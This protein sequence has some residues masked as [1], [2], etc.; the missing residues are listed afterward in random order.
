LPRISLTAGVNSISSDLFVLQ[1]RDNPVW[2][3]GANL[4][5][6]IFQGGALKAQVEIRTAEQK[7]A[8]AEYARAALRAFGEAENALA[9]EIASQD[10]EQILLRAVAENDRALELAKVSFNVGSID[11]RPVQ[12]Q[13]LAL[14][15]T[16][17]ALV[18]VQSE[19]RLQRVNLHLALGG[20]WQAA[21]S[22]EAKPAATGAAPA[23]QQSA[24][25]N[26][27]PAASSAPT[28][29]TGATA[30]QDR[31]ELSRDTDTWV[32]NVYHEKGIGGVA[33]TAPASGWPRSMRTRFHG[34]PGLEKLT[35]KAGT[36]L[37]ACETRRPE[38]RPAEDIC[39]LNGVRTIAPRKLP[40]IYEV[41]LP[42]DILV[43]AHRTLELRWVD[44]WR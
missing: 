20:G 25:T 17:S 15:A 30:L 36:S 23:V 26:A 9:S 6:P 39:T 7:Q 38:G 13:Q 29:N 28:P 27:K 40:G 31:T 3:A 11:M 18:R 37:F 19:Q 8:V 5:A 33:I 34:F 35:A 12:Q 2:S 16:R 32:L 42:S 10:R 24:P 1:D 21:T 14:Y 41:D 4:I 43:S 44:Q 22:A